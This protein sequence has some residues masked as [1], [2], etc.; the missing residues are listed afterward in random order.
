MTDLTAS[1]TDTYD[2][3][4]FG[5]LISRTG[6]TPNDY[7]YSGE[8]F[9][10]NL[11]FY[12]LRARYMNPASGRFVSTDSFGGNKSDPT[13]LHKYLY[14]N[15]DPISNHDPSGYASI[16]E[17]L[18][19]FGV[20]GVLNT[21]STLMLKGLIAGTI[22]GGADAGLRGD[23]IIDGAIEGG[24]IGAL[25]GPLGKVKFVGTALVAL[26]TS[27]AFVGVVDAIEQDNYQ[28]AA[29]RS[30]LALAGVVTLVRPEAPAFTVPA[31][32]PPTGG[33]LG[34]ASTRAQLG[35]IADILIDRGWE[36]TRG[37]GLGPEEYLPPLSGSGTRGGNYVDLILV[38]VEVWVIT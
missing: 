24:L 7:L 9:D 26:G 28:L 32:Q 15:V 20:N 14:A 13:S 3:D 17:T 29:F 5:N 11:G 21:I 8:Q 31:S 30:I 22:I 19:T 10:A 18:T 2:Y 36:V 38:N 25:L 23:D 35:D 27:A 1:V 37:G 6:T 34:S 4:A 16:S 12:Y 33:R